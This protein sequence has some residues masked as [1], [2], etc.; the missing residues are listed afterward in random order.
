M[1]KSAT[2]IFF[3]SCWI[4]TSIAVLGVDMNQVQCSSADFAII[5]AWDGDYQQS[6]YIA[7]CVANA[8]AAG[9]QHVDVYAFMCPNCGGNNPPSTA[10][11]SLINSLSSQ[12]VKYGMLWFDIE[13]CSGC[14]NDAASA[15]QFIQSATNT[16]AGMGVNIGIYSSS[17]EWQQ[18][19][20]SASAWSSLP[21]WYAHYDGNP[22]F[23]D[24]WAYQFGG[25]TK[26]AIKQYDDHGP[27]GVDVDVDYY[28]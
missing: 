23:S 20:G 13:Q 1:F 22:S 7:Q 5:Q 9:M 11:R 4:T 21:L 19:V 6:Q 27:C 28:P 14:W 18:T 8:W 25:W 26:P 3:L 15:A 17:Y 10:I 12:N 2:L 16:A 24:S